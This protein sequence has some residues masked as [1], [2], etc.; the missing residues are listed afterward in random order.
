MN[1]CGLHELALVGVTVKVTVCGDEVVLT[2]FDA[3]TVPPVPL[4]GRPVTLVV[5]FLVH[6]KAVP[7]TFAPKPMADIEPPEQIV[8]FEFDTVVVR[9]GFTVTEIPAAQPP[10]LAAM[11]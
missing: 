3:G 10:A 8:A 9:T 5:L 2:K 1:G 6:E 7:A 4:A 11:L